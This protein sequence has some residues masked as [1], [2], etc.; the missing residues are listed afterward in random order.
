MSIP[1]AVFAPLLAGRRFL[2]IGR[3]G[4]R[5]LLLHDVPEEEMDSYRRLLDT[6]ARHHGFVDPADFDKTLAGRPDSRTPV[7]VSFD[8]GFSSNLAAARLLAAEYGGRALLFVCP[9]L[10]DLTGDARRQAVAANVF[11]GRR[12]PAEVPALLEWDEIATLAAEG[13]VIGGHTLTHR[14]LPSLA[15][16][17]MRRE[18]VE[19]GARIAARLDRS[20]DWFAFPFGTIDDVSAEVLAV[21][22]EHYRWCRS[23]VRGLNRPG[24][25]AMGLLAEHVGLADSQAKQ[26]LALEGGLDF[27]HFR[28]R[29]RLQ[30]MLA[31]SRP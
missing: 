3:D 9:G 30:R 20:V 16:E 21:A 13:H 31:A 15:V 18:I 26:C 27:R 7:L 5:I 17:E 11:R 14:H 28:A 10:I 24:T 8:D 2:G 4:V 12:S 29:R 22:A 19:S 25:P 23:G 1:S 6:I